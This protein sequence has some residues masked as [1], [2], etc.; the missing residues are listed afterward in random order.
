MVLLAKK[1]TGIIGAIELYEGNATVTDP[2]FQ[3]MR[4]RQDGFNG[5]VLRQGSV[6]HF[7]LRHMKKTAPTIRRLARS[8]PSTSIAQLKMRLEQ[9]GEEARIP[10]MHAYVAKSVGY[11]VDQAI[12]AH[13]RRTGDRLSIVV[14]DV[15]SLLVRAAGSDICR[16]FMDHTG[17][18][19]IDRAPVAH[20]LKFVFNERG[21]TTFFVE[22]DKLVRAA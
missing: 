5:R 6:P 14:T 10:L 19:A 15:P 13:G 8:F 20:G 12:G 9:G 7:D 2:A 4:L 18:S 17:R 3:V 11:L 21:L 22:N 16:A 1:L